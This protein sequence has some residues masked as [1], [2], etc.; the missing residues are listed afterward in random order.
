MIGPTDLLHPSPA[1]HFKTFQ[2]LSHY[3]RKLKED[4]RVNITYIYLCMSH[5]ACCHSMQ[6]L[7]S[8]SFLS[9]KIKD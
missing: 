3:M 1:Q 9:Q 4:A 5:I 7:L 6:N 2:A 8:S